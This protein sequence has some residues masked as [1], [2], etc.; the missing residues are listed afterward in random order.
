MSGD[1][2]DQVHRGLT[3]LTSRIIQTPHG[4]DLQEGTMYAQGLATLALC[5][6]Y[7][8]TQ[9]ETFRGPAQQ[10]VNFICAAQHSGG[11]WRYFPGQPGDTTVLGWQMMALKSAALAGLQMPSTVV[12][13]G[14]HFLDGVQSGEGAYYGYLSRGKDPG[15]T[16]IGL[17]IRMYGGWNHNN[18]ALGRGVK[19]LAKLGP[20]SHDMYY[21]Y[22]ATQVLHHYGGVTWP[23][24]NRKMREHL[25]R[26]QAATGHQ[27]GSWFFRDEHGSTGGRLYTTAM[28][29]MIL[30]V[31]YR[32]MP[33]YGERAVEADWR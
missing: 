5:E 16:A 26:T 12:E 4:A 17:L 11:G 13:G 6:A 15:P 2:Q 10:A 14:G 3:Y 28:C 18:P 7:A 31:Y 27:L 20:S 19:Y 25:I 9:D 21:N 8:M 22:Y 33:L 29:I 32:H 24:W 30:E 23:P 1:Y